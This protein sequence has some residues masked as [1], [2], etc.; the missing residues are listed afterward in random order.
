[1]YV[2]VCVCA[3]THVCMYVDCMFGHGIC[4]C[5]SM[6]VQNVCTCC[7]RGSSLITLPSLF[8]RGPGSCSVSL[9]GP[10]R[11]ER[12]HCPLLLLLLLTLASPGAGARLLALLPAG[13]LVGVLPPALASLPP[14]L[15]CNPTAGR[16]KTGHH[17]TSREAP[18]MAM[19][20]GHGHGPQDGRGE[21]GGKGRQ[22]GA[23][24]A[25]LRRGVP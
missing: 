11:C 13:V 23:G 19:D 15:P 10:C 22:G 5:V 21:E 18:G 25:A 7:P 24:M 14:P 17:A 8:L 12:P 3:H 16:F 20:P 6:C 9:G 4:V 2:C 1:M